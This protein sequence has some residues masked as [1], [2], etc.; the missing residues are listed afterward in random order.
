M[1]EV[2]RPQ[3]RVGGRRGANSGHERARPL[4]HTSPL[5][6]QSEGGIRLRHGIDV[7]SA[8]LALVRE[9]FRTLPAAGANATAC[10]R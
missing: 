5:I 2:R 3:L 6:E 8:Q 1:S 9:L 10:R 4:R 7:R